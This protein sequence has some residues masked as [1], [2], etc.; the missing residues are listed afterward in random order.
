MA[1]VPRDSGR[2]WHTE[3]VQ[4]D[5]AWGLAPARSAESVAKWNCTSGQS[6]AGSAYRVL[7][8]ARPST[9]DDVSVLMPLFVGETCG[10]IERD[11]GP[12]VDNYLS[13]LSD[14]SAELLAQCTVDSE[15]AKLQALLAQMRQL[16][17]ERV[18]GAM[19][20]FETPRACVER[21]RALEREL[22]VGRVIG[23]FNFGGMVPHQR[24]LDSMELF[25]RKVM[26][27]LALP[28]AA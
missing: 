15:R 7:T 14:A 19:G 27:E 21:L 13:V 16:S 10:Q 17:F 11:L 5:Q 4:P 8:N 1:T 24:V 18:N 23:W 2:S 9:P 22:G 26:P 25:A 20:I 12:S 3:K 6:P 28:C